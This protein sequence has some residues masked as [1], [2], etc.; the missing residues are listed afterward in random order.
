MPTRAMQ[1]AST[2]YGCWFS[3]G[4][5]PPTIEFAIKSINTKFYGDW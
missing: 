1:N 4:W 5:P 3:C 2:R